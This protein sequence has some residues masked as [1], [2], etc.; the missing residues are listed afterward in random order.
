MPRNQ[1]VD[2]GDSD[3]SAHISEQIIQAAGISD[4]FILQRAHCGCRQRNENHAGRSTAQDN[5]PE[6]G[7]LRHLER[8]MRKPDT[9]E[10][11][12]NESCG[13]QVSIVDLAGQYADDWHDQN[14]SDASRANRQTRR[15]RRV[16]HKV[17]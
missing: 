7:P 13:N 3:A 2:D 16:T 15:P 10:T 5:G 11:K 1:R 9:C 17:W 4:L 8:Q 6:H 14:G 12:Q